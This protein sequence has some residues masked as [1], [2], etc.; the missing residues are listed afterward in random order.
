MPT[1]I[2]RE[3]GATEQY[4]SCG[5]FCSRR[6]LAILPTRRAIVPDGLVA[7]RVPLVLGGICAPTP[8]RPTSS[9]ALRASEEP[10]T[11]SQARIW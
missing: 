11:S 4:A 10:A 5:I 8:G 7:R 3:W 6:D 9:L 2:S 1:V